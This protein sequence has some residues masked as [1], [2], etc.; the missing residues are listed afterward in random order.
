MAPRFFVLPVGLEVVARAATP[1][2][3]G[4]K[5]AAERALLRKRWQ[6]FDKR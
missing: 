5:S 6:V 1:R 2:R 4:L 3:G